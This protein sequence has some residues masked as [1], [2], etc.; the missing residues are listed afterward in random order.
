MFR[1]YMQRKRLKHSSGTW[2]GKWGHPNR[3]TCAW[4]FCVASV[5]MPQQLEED[6]EHRINPAQNET[7][8]KDPPWT[9]RAKTQKKNPKSK[10]PQRRE[11]SEMVKVFPKKLPNP[12]ISGPKMIK[13]PKKWYFLKAIR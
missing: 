8:Q 7:R 13:F 5:S 11:T 2:Y 6:K 4:P 12:P 3:Y 9:D 1:G 10:A